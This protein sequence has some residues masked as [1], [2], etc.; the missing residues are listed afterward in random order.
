V[1]DYFSTWRDRGFTCGRCAWTGTA[2]EASHELFAELFEVNCP[3]YDARLDLVLYRGAR[4]LAAATVNPPG[5]APHPGRP[6]CHAE[7]FLLDQP[8]VLSVYLDGF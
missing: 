2:E 7:A 8:G 1:S 4:P 3:L 6:R 5:T